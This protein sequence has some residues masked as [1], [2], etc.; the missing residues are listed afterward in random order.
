MRPLQLTIAGLRSYGADEPVVIDFRGKNNV[1]VIGRTGAGKSSLFEAMSFAL[2]RQSSWSAQEVSSLIAHGASRVSVELS[3]VHDGQLWTVLRAFYTN[4]R[5]SIHKLTCESTGETVDGERKVTERIEQLLGVSAETFHRV[6]LL[7]QGRFDRLLTAS[8]AERITMLNELLGIGELESAREIASRQHDGLV[9]AL[10]AAR[11]ARGRMAEDPQ[12]AAQQAH[13][14]ALE[15]EERARRLDGAHAQLRTLQITVLDLRAR[16]TDTGEA[17]DA[18]EALDPSGADRRL[19]G[20]RALHE[21]FAAEQQGLTQQQERCIAQADQADAEIRRL[22]AQGLTPESV[23][24]AELTIAQL[25]ENARQLRTRTA[26]LT[27]RVNVVAAERSL[28]ADQAAKL[29]EMTAGAA[30]AKARA[31]RADQEATSAAKCRESVALAEAGL[32]HTGENLRAAQAAHRAALDGVTVFEA[33]AKAADAGAGDA[34]RAFERA[35]ARLPEAGMLQRAEQHVHDLHTAVLDALSTGLAAARAVAESPGA[36][37][38]IDEIAGRL[39]GEQATLET[40]TANLTAANGRI[41]A[42]DDTMA[43]LDEA[44]EELKQT[45]I[46]CLQAAE[47]RDTDRNQLRQAK[48]TLTAAG[49]DLEK[50]SQ[51]QQAAY[52]A[53]AEARDAHERVERGAMAAALARNLAPGGRCPVCAQDLPDHFHP[54]D[55]SATLDIARAEEAAHATQQAYTARQQQYATAEAHSAAASEAVTRFEHAVRESD[56]RRAAHL[57]KA[58]RLHERASQMLAAAGF[59]LAADSTAFRT[60]LE[61]QTPSARSAASTA[62]A[63]SV[64]VTAHRVLEPLRATQALAEAELEEQRTLASQLRAASA[65]A[66]KAVDLL[67]S[68]LRTAKTAAE[69]AARRAAA[70]RATA[71]ESMTGL[72]SAHE[73]ALDAIAALTGTTPESTH[74]N[75]SRAVTGAL[76]SISTQPTESAWRASTATGLLMPLR[77]ALESTRS[78][79]EAQHA[80]AAAL[81]AAAA[82]AQT[83]ANGKHEA[84]IRARAD[85]TRLGAAAEAAQGRHDES[86]AVLTTAYQQAN[87][88]LTRGGH[89]LKTELTEAAARSAAEAVAACSPEHPGHGDTEDNRSS[90]AIEIANAVAAIGTDATEAERLAAD[91]AANLTIFQEGLAATRMRLDQD[92]ERNQRDAGT[93]EADRLKIGAEIVALPE[94]YRSLLPERVDEIRTEHLE[95]ARRAVLATALALRTLLGQRNEAHEHR[96]RIAQDLIELASQRKTRVENPLTELYEQLVNTSTVVAAQRAHAQLQEPSQAPEPPAVAERTIDAVTRYAA[97]VADHRRR[98]LDALAES[99]AQLHQRVTAHLGELEEATA[100]LSRDHGIDGVG[101]PCDPALLEKVTAARTLAA[102][103]A[104]EARKRRAQVLADIPRAAALDDAIRA[105]QLRAANLQNVKTLLNK[106]RF[107]AFLTMRRTEALL[108]VATRLLGTLSSGQ[109]GF[110][111]NFQII[112]R[113]TS[114]V[115][116]PKTLSGG[117]KFLAS[118]ALALAMVELYSRNGPRLGSLFLDEGFASLDEDTLDTALEVVRQ[119]AGDER[120]VVLISHLQIVAQAVDDVL[121]VERGPSGSSTARWL[122]D[123]GRD[124]MLDNEIRTGLLE[125]A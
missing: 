56:A 64:R 77:R 59:A 78:E 53:A 32:R 74:E 24:R 48:G 13:A 62:P 92:H 55:D 54:A 47:E 61:Q 76:A 7:H 33:D 89:P 103:A 52:A 98:A 125:L 75:L 38:G 71:D 39:R 2:Y 120:L 117:E 115:R 29:G 67:S 26:Q 70:A 20:L 81:Q 100:G 79:H 108:A 118:L 34:L 93:L 99:S 113:T 35:H 50:A 106:D 104:T 42:L 80:A 72:R 11:V 30:Q 122:D 60:V 66:A 96:D 31:V 119:Q 9:G 85:G 4:R 111:A 69:Q 5:P 68:E 95:P 114:G 88:A 58:A 94:R 121:W 112:E 110:A 41:T 23:A 37:A 87:T 86:L 16:C 3:F 10:A 65:A 105:G 15:S 22:A 6:V 84:V 40:A 82:A 123:E 18:I 27:E 73:R 107:P 49:K 63:A 45:T 97:A 19:P 25:P 36:A 17:R 102:H 116:D 28:F 14:E 21:R 83:D 46:D 90:L 43:S 1:G 57:E 101:D 8:K 91:L 124:A 12:H 51:E 44:T 109:F